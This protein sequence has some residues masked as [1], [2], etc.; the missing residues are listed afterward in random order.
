MMLGKK[1]ARSQPTADPTDPAIKVRRALDLLSQDSGQLEA[2]LRVERG[3]LMAMVAEID[4]Q[5]AILKA[6]KSLN[7]T[8]LDANER[9]EGGTDETLPTR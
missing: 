9:T 3:N 7:S 5:L 8:N 4:S 2:S 6:L 1:R